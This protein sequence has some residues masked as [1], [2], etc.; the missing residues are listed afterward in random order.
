[1]EMFSLE[2]S[3]SQCTLEF[4]SLPVL[5]DS[6]LSKFIDTWDPVKRDDLYLPGVLNSMT[7]S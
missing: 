1:M 4:F 3:S 7:E 5:T 6:V 2:L